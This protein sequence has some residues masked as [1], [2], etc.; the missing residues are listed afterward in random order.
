VAR[1][2]QRRVV[3]GVGLGDEAGGSLLHAHGLLPVDGGRG[4]LDTPDRIFQTS[5]LNTA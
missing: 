1:H 3:E 5:N 4:S 2:V